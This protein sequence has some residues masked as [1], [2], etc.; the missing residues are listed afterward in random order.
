MF[1]K[2]YVMLSGNAEMNSLFLSI[3]FFMYTGFFGIKVFGTLSSIFNTGG[4]LLRSFCLFI[5]FATDDILLGKSNF[6][7][8]AIIIHYCVHIVTRI[9]YSFEILYKLKYQ[10]AHLNSLIASFGKNL[11]IFLS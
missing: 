8:L 3:H 10:L 1:F 6:L 5:S 9:F 7:L 2:Q 11:I 4:N